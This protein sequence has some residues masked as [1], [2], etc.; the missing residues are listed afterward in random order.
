MNAALPLPGLGGHAAVVRAMARKVGRV[1]WLI[2]PVLAATALA[3]MSGK[4]NVVAATFCVAMAVALHLTWW[5]AASALMGQNDPLSAHL[6]PGQLQRL[7][8]TAVVVFLVLAAACG[9]LIHA[10]LGHG[11]IVTMAA[12]V[13]MLG[14]VACLR[15]PWLWVAIWFLP[16]IV[17][18]TLREIPLAMEAWG[19]MKTWHVRQPFTQT[20]AVLLLSSAGLWRLFQAGGAGHA[21]AWQRGQRMRQLMSMQGGTR[22]AGGPRSS[23]WMASLGRPF[24]WALPLWREHLLRNAQPTAASVTARALLAALR[25]LHW[26]ALGS[27][28]VL[29][30]VCFLLAEAWLLIYLPDRAG[31]VIRAAM[32]G[33]SIGLMS[34]ML[35]PQFGVAATLFQSRREQ[36]LLTLLPGMPRGEAMNRA[37]G[38]R[39]FLHYVGVWAA[40]LTM[41]LVMTSLASLAPVAQG[42]SDPED[43][44]LLGLNFAA[45]ALPAGLLVWRDW[46]R[47]TVPSGAKIA[48]LTMSLLLL[49]GLSVVATRVWMFSPLWLVAGSVL[50]TGALA[51]WRWRAL[52]RMAPFWPVGRLAGD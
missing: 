50:L 45:V 7:R 8:E 37:V 41:I 44:L 10:A 14:F 30:F 19:A 31:A 18:P 29:L 27:T 12:A 33:V 49:M 20:A 5:A 47:Q 46:S 40:G 4:A 26:S 22:L 28:A 51:A 21:S 15:W 42:G 43:N 11:L 3:T 35:S 25:G 39:M 13:F 24:Q 9:L 34:A 2:L 32:P 6:L 36:A 17:L 38:A 52:G 48:M 1:W 16:W 23:G